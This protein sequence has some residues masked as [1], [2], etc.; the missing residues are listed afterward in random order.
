MNKHQRTR[1]PAEEKERSYKRDRYVRAE[2]PHAFRKQWPR[3]KAYAQ[4]KYR[5]QTRQAV[6]AA[7]P[8]KISADE[9]DDIDVESVRRVPIRKWGF[10]GETT[11]RLEDI[12]Q[13]RLERRAQA[14]LTRFFKYAYDSNRD[15]ERFEQFLEAVISSDSA[16]NQHIVQAFQQLLDAPQMVTIAGYQRQSRRS[17]WL[18]TFLAD[19]PVWAKRLESRIGEPNPAGE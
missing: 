1:F 7:T 17:A 13:Q 8:D 11:A 10:P 3:K 16:L 9:L 19:Q 6:Q 4:R 18:D 15:R 5:H 2:Y 12:I 14:A